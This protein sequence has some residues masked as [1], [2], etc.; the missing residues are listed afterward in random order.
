MKEKL[1]LRPVEKDDL[2]FIY[3]M[4]INPDVSN[5]WCEEP[6]TTMEKLTKSY[7]TSQD[8]N[9]HR[10]FILMSGEE[11]IGFLALYG[12]ESRHRNAEFAIM[13]DP[14]QQGKGYAT[15]ATRLLVDY[16]FYQLNLHKLY[17]YVVKHNEKAIHI[18]QKVG[19]QTEGELKKHYFIDGQYY[20]GYIMGLLREDYSE[21]HQ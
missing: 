12:I 11:R 6:Y 3:Q 4:Q 10:Q 14:G 20:D 8:N 21:S 18:Y 7:E 1:R 2:A 15:E 19:F 13:I 17:L 16:G 9:F 5:Y